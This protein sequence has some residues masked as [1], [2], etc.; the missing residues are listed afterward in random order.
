MNEKAKSTLEIYKQK[1]VYLN[2]SPRTIESYCYYTS[3]FLEVQTKSA[4]NLSSQDF[5]SY[6]DNYPFTSISQQNQIINAIQFLYIQVLNKKYQK[7]NFQR[8]KGETKLP[9]VIEK[10]FLL[11]CLE[12]IKNKKHRT[13]LSLAYSVGL[14]VSEV[15]DLKIENIDSK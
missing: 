6:L 15:I 9:D 14:R 4:V 11:S 1:L 7:V 5:Q 10:K 12:K 8:P 13:I 2:Y 3:K